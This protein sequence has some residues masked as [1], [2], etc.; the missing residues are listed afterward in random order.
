[1]IQIWKASA[2]AMMMWSKVFCE[3]HGDFGGHTIQ[4][5]N[6]SRS[7]IQTIMNQEKLKFYEKNEGT[8]VNMVNNN[9]L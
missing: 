1:M 4:H 9:P 6:E 5:C 7:K 2:D 3:F 8:V